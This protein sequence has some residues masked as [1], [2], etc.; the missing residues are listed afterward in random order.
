MLWLLQVI[1]SEVL[2]EETADRASWWFSVNTTS[3]MQGK[4]LLC[5]VT[6]QSSFGTIEF[7]IE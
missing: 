5:H 4:K 3:D 6:L 7:T 2:T 1:G